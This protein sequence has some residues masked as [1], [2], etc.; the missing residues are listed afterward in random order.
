LQQL[1]SVSSEWLLDMER[2]EMVFSQGLF[3]VN[4]L[5]EQT[6]F[7][8]E[9]NEGKI[10][11]FVNMIPNFIACEAN[12]DLM[13]KTTDAPNGTMD[14]LFVK[15]FE[16]LKL[17]E[18]LSCNLGMV[19]LS[20]IDNPKNILEQAMKTAYEKMKI[21]SQYKNLYNFKEKYDPT[22]S[23]TYLVFNESF[24]LTLIPSALKKIMEV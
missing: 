11:G 6:I 22:W 24:D 19:P 9:S 5:K 14:F 16:H 20:G 2:E 17:K 10:V 7:T 15:M 8:I 13:R 23:E 3:S 21:F 1:K 18:Y 4:E 12:F